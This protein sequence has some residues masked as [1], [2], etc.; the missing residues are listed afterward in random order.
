M[1]CTRSTPYRERIF[2]RAVD[3]AIV[4]DENFANIPGDLLEV[5]AQVG[6][7]HVCEMRRPRPVCFIFSRSRR[8]PRLPSLLSVAPATPAPAGTTPSR[9]ARSANPVT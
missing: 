5:A 3:G 4:T 7:F 2:L 1:M 8:L 6:R 9:G